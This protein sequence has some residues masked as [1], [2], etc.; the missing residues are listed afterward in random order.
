MTSVLT[1]DNE[2]SIY[3]YFSTFLQ[4][5]PA[6]QLTSTILHFVKHHGLQFTVDYLKQH[7]QLYKEFLS[8]G[9]FPVSIRGSILPVFRLKPSDALRCLNIY[10]CVV[11]HEVTDRQVKKFQDAVELPPLEVDATVCSEVVDNIVDV[12]KNDTPI[13]FHPYTWISSVKK[14]SPIFESALPSKRLETDVSWSMWMDSIHNAP[15][16]TRA[17]YRSHASLYAKGLWMTERAFLRRLMSGSVLYPNR[18]HLLRN[19][20]KSTAN[21]VGRLG[22][23]QESGCKL[24][25][26]ANLNRENQAA[27][28]GLGDLL[29]KVLQR[30]PWDCTF[31][32]SKGTDFVQN[33]LL[34]NKTVFSYDLSNATDSFPLSY[35]ISVVSKSLLLCNLRN[36]NV[37]TNKENYATINDLQKSLE[38]FALISRADW[39][40]PTQYWSKFKKP[41]LSWTKG[42]PLG[43]FPSFA[44]FA[45]SHGNLVR[46]IEL[47]EGLSDTFRVLGD[48]I[49]ITDPY[50]AKRYV[51]VMTEYGCSISIQKSIISREIGEFAGK[52]IDKKGIIPSP[53]WQAFSKAN[54][55]GPCQVLGHSGLQFVPT[56]YRSSVEVFIG[57]PEPVGLGINPKG[58]PLD[59]RLVPEVLEWFYTDKTNDLTIQYSLLRKS[60][61][62]DTTEIV[63]NRF[64]CF[65]LNFHGT[66]V[67]RGVINLP[68]RV[69]QTLPYEDI[70]RVQH[71]NAVIRS[72]KPWE[73]I[74]SALQRP[75]IEESNLRNE[76]RPHKDNPTLSRIFKYLRILKRSKA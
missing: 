69:D 40:V 55:T 59:V 43:A 31:D 38:L 20:V 21:I 49:V 65:Q 53:K 32:Q 62:C 8:S 52:I 54:P 36:I 29:Y 41:F 26:V 39:F 60:N 1:L 63:K 44:L 23:I 56:S 64:R 73:S 47:E 11:L 2:N 68:R 34:Q 6:K 74:P 25:V 50:V 42:Q 37:K 27:L 66:F 76:V 14:V 61:D 45:I 13:F 72:L 58:L 28:S 35:Q 22:F 19:R 46:S 48:D 71:Y 15:D 10:S 9:E 4:P 5:S 24:R 70:V 51:E 30:L 16:K 18:D 67:P 12:V 33:A 7:K 3:V 75:V 17:M 57:L